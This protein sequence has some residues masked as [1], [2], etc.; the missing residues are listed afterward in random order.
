[1]TAELW[2]ENTLVRCPQLFDEQ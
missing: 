1:M 2:I